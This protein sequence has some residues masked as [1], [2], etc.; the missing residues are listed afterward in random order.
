MMI[1]FSKKY[2]AQGTTIRDLEET[3]QQFFAVVCFVA[4]IQFERIP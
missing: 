1:G 2:R 4:A 3:C